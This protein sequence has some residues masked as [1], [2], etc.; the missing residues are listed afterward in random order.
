MK[1]Q[2]IQYKIEK[3]LEKLWYFPIKLIKTNKPWIAD[4]LV[5]LWNWKHLRIEV[6]QEKWKESKIQEYRR[7]QLTDMGDICLIVYWY[8]D[9]I[10]KK[11]SI[12]N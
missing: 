7:K 10:N 1:E 8:E 5:L 9:F 11:T 12:L 4:L 3:Y 2:A 6:K